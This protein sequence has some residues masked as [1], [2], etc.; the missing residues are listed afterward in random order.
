M[1]NYTV[2]AGMIKNSE[3]KILLLD[4]KKTG[5]W[6]IPLGKVEPGETSR[7]GLEREMKEEVG[8]DVLQSYC[9][10]KDWYDFPQGPTKT[11]VY[12]VNYYQG[13]PINK[14]PHKHSGMKWMTLS[15]IR[16]FRLTYATQLL[17][18]YLDEVADAERAANPFA[19]I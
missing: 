15:E 14:E 17:L 5:C 4:H 2:V 11:L 8:I 7:Q 12:N 6:T 18:H 13:E 16:G 1:T 9:M 3:G 10:A 19:R